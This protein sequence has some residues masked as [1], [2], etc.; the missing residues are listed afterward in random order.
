MHSNSCSTG[1]L[2]TSR[3]TH[4]KFPSSEPTLGRIIKKAVISSNDVSS[5]RD[6]EKR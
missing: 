2:P 4:L 5:P 3:R 6:W 1:S